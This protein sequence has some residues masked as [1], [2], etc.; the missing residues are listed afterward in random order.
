MGVYPYNK[1]LFNNTEKWNIGACY[2][3][4]EPQ[5]HAQWKKTDAKVPILH[6]SISMKYLEKVNL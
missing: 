4:D 5:E 3:T 2:N 6:D 1:I